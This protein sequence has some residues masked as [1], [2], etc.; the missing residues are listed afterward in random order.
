MPTDWFSA[1]LNAFK[2]GISPSS[3]I[4]VDELLNR[5]SLSASFGFTTVKTTA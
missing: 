5:Y 3:R 2:V 4:I 1:D